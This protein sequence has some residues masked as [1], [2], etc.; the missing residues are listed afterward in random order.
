MN[1]FSVAFGGKADMPFAL[2]MSAFDP[3]QTLPF[4][5]RS[6][7]GTICRLQLRGQMCADVNLS[8]CSRVRP[9]PDLALSSL[10]SRRECIVSA[11]S[12]PPGR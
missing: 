3:K 12:V 7:V 2:H 11:V 10:S 8:G 5:T 4:H 6:F 9:L 1:A